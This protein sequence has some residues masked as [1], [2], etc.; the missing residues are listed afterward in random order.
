MPR[1]LR[2][3]SIVE[4][5]VVI[6][7][8]GTLIALLLPA[9][10]VARESARRNTCQNRLRQMA[11]AAVKYHDSNRGFMPGDD[12]HDTAYDG[13]E[14]NGTFGWPFFLA[15][16]FEY[17]GPTEMGIT[18]YRLRTYK[19]CKSRGTSSGRYGD[20]KHRD[21]ATNQPAE[22]VC[23]SSGNEYPASLKDYA[24]NAGTM[25]EPQWRNA[26]RRVSDTDGLGY[27]HSRIRVDQ[28][29]DGLSKTI[30]F[31]ER[32]HSAPGR[33][34]P[35]GAGGNQFIWV[36]FNRQGYVVFDDQFPDAST[37][38]SKALMLPYRTAKGAALAPYSDHS[39]VVNAAFADGN[40]RSISDDVGAAEY[41]T[42]VRRNDGSR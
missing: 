32:R 4:L 29:V 36:D 38:N 19:D 39:G 20:W 41:R 2:A 15:R 12:G 37:L 5:L 30:L 33:C 6:A 31:I 7:I 10:Q 1:Q 14:A 26:T 27:S 23:P 28:I 17:E 3:F 42:M 24:V 35:E 25:R 34:L 22:F 40:V 9:I 16:F 11:L 18:S 13:D 8:M 21:L